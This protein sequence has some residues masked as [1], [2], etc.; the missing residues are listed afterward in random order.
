MLAAVPRLELI[1]P[2]L[3]WNAAWRPDPESDLPKL[4]EHPEGS[5]CYAAVGVLR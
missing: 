4:L 3:V 5:A 1:E 2:A